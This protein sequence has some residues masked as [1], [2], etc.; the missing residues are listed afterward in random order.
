MIYL[1]VRIHKQ[2]VDRGLCKW[3][4]AQ[5]L[6]C[7][8]KSSREFQFL[9]K[10]GNIQI[11]DHRNPYLCFDGVDAVSVEMSNSQVLFD[12]AEKQLHLPTHSVKLGYHFR[13]HIEQV[14]QVHIDVAVFRIAIP[15]PAKWPWI[16]FAA[17]SRSQQPDLIAAQTGVRVDHPGVLAIE[18]R[19]FLCPDHEKGPGF[20]DARQ[21]GVVEVSAIHQ[22]DCPRFEDQRI[23]PLHIVFS[24]LGDVDTCGDRSTKIDLCV[25]FDTSLGLP[26][27]SPWK[28]RQGEVDGRRIQ[29]IHRVA[30]IYIQ[31]LS[32]IETSCFADQ[33]LGNGFPDLPVPGFVGIGKGGLRQRPCE[34]QMMKSFGLGVETIDDVPQTFPP[35]Q[36]RE[37][38]RNKLLATAKML[39][40][41]VAVELLDL[42]IEGFSVNLSSDL[43]YDICTC[44]HGL[45]YIEQ[46]SQSKAS[47]QFFSLI[48]LAA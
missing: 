35:C 7:S 38:H 46:N 44:S 10:D 3:V 36:L 15:D 37:S 30:E 26:E 22:I 4:Y 14:G 2:F 47:H 23:Q 21:A 5:N 45:A 41:V 32:D 24:G 11:N 43:R 34:A 42:P 12:P 48:N 16:G 19:I 6:K 1:E 13:L 27:R 18:Y 28:Q 20:V 8:V 40:F 29:S 31:I 17:C 39:H 9:V 25:Q 33:P